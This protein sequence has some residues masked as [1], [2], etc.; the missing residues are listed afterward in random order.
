MKTNIRLLMY[1]HCLIPILSRIKL[2]VISNRSVEV[3]KSQPCLYVFGTVIPK[4]KQTSD[5]KFPH[6][7][8]MF[9]THSVLFGQVLAVSGVKLFVISNWYVQVVKPQP[10]LDYFQN[11]HSKMKTNIRLW[12]YT[13][14][15]T[16]WYPFCLVWSS[17]SCFSGEIVGYK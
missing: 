10:Y 8:E 17:I 16:V 4:W 2:L 9:G 14:N 15:G 6:Q 12:I 7:M 11:N 13:A 5:Y 1:T 3:V